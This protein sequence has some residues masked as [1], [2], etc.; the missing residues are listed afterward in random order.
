V[1]EEQ[2]LNDY[3]AY[4]PT[5]SGTDD[6][7]TD[8]EGEDENGFGPFSDLNKLWSWFFMEGPGSMRTGT[9]GW[10]VVVEA[11][12]EPDQEEADDEESEEEEG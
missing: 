1:S 2:F 7:D 11:G 5:A 9:A 3:Q 6:E 8:E 12:D 4:W 10:R